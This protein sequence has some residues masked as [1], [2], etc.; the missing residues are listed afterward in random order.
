MKTPNRH[1]PR[2]QKAIQEYRG[3]ITIVHKY[4]NIHKNA[5]GLSRFHLLSTTDTPAYVPE[6]AS[7]Q[8]A[9][10]GIGVTD[11]NIT[12][13]EEVKKGWNP[14][15]HQDSSRKDLVE[16]HPTAASFKKM[17][18][19]TRKHAVRCMEDPFAYAKDKWDKSNATPDFKVGDLVLVSTTVTGALGQKNKSGLALSNQGTYLEDSKRINK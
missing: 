11:L 8:I 10:E 14:K 3:N 7:P 1:I 18:D 4:G 15:L 17:L 9:I 5:Y 19:K 2:W 16:I 6:E 12:L 13:F